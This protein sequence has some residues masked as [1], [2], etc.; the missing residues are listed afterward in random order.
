MRE[1]ERLQEEIDG[2]V[3]QLIRGWTERIHYRVAVPTDC[4]H[5]NCKCVAA[6]EARAQTITHAG[7][8]DQLKL[9]QQQGDPGP[10][11]GAERGAP[12][13]PGSRPP[14]NMKGFHLLDEIS[15]EIMSF[16]QECAERAGY[17]PDVA[18]VSVAG[19][20]GNIRRLSTSAYDRDE[21]LAYD[22]RNRLRGWVRRCRLALAHDQPDEMLADTVCGECGGGLAVGRG[23]ETDVRCVG[24]PEQP[25]C[26]VR[27]GRQDWVALLEAQQ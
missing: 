14:G 20:L 10:R 15:V 17:G 12:N 22:I 23:A 27:Y 9:F 21:L 25:P 19:N 2:L 6:T 1:I 8:L 4:A 16:G 5:I 7:L 11:D 18:L 13:K 3:D 26:G 24:T